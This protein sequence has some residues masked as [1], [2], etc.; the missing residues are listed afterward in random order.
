[1]AHEADRE[2]KLNGEAD[3]GAINHP[4]DDGSAAVALSGAP[5]EFPF[6]SFWFT[7]RLLSRSIGFISVVAMLILW[8]LS[9]S[10]G[11][12][13]PLLLPE[14]GDVVAA[15]FHVLLHGYRDTSLVDDVAATVGRCLAGFSLAI[16]VGIPLGLAMGMSRRVAALFGYIV[17]FL[18]P[19]PP[20]S[21]MI[22][23]I[24]WFGTGEG[25]KI[26]LLFL[27]ASPIIVSAA[28]AGV[29]TVPVQRLQVAAMLG[30][31]RRQTFWQV[32]LPS[33]LPM[34]FTG[35]KIALAAAF[36]TVVAAEFISARMGLGWL[37][38]SASKYLQN[39][40]IIMGVVLL[41]LIGMTL[42]R[43]LHVLDVRFI[44]WRRVG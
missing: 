31:S 15:F 12:I 4:A 14:P 10:T 36:S 39:A 21:Y 25:S 23:L 33:A 1:L 9:V 42:S 22:L 17:Q 11:L 34:I 38:L 5:R 18:R 35:L 27:T 20:L 6:G 2:K 29:H 32:V 7:G 19:L 8:Q 28:M 37:V 43:L 13:S 3:S 16:V 44:H 30:A 26:V 40:T 24:L 41:G